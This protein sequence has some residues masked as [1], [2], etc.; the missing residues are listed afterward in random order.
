MIGREEI[1]EMSQRVRAIEILLP[2]V[3][4]HGDVLWR[5]Q[6]LTWF[7]DVDWI[8]DDLEVIAGNQSHRSIESQPQSSDPRVRRISAELSEAF[9]VQP[10]APKTRGEIAYDRIARVLAQESSL[11]P[12]IHVFDNGEHLVT[13]YGGRTPIPPSGPAGEGE[14]AG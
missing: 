14:G 4:H 6:V 5:S 3:A 12:R 8:P 1:S 9:G 7:A 11:G 10:P 13:T 2:E